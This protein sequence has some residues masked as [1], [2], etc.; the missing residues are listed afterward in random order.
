MLLFFTLSAANHA[1]TAIREHNLKPANLMRPIMAMILVGV[2]LPPM[3]KALLSP[4]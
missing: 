3:I 4:G 2:L 1:A